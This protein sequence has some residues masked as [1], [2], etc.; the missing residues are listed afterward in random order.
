LWLEEKAILR[1][2]MEEQAGIGQSPNDV[3][4]NVYNE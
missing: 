2:K 4:Q 3:L 1:F